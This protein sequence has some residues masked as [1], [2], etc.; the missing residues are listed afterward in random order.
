MKFKD[1]AAWCNERACDG[2]WGLQTALACIEIESSVR[3]KSFWKREKAWQKINSEWH[4]EELVVNEINNM[5]L[6]QEGG[7]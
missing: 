3:S 2:R 6:E 5:I 4:I 1:F 7:K